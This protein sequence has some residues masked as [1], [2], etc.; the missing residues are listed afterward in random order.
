MNGYA[1]LVLEDGTIIHG[2][3]IG[4]DGDRVGEVIF[5]TAMCGYQEIITDP[6]YCRQIITFSY[7]HIGNTGV[8]KEDEESN[9]I[10]ASGIVIGNR[11][12]HHPHHRSHESLIAYLHRHQTVA[13]AGVD[14]RRLIHLLRKKG[15]QRACITAAPTPIDVTSALEKARAF[16]GLGGMDLAQEVGHQYDWP[17]ND[18]ARYSVVA[19][20]FGIKR[21]ILRLMAQ[22]DCSI[23]VVPATTPAE[24]V[25]AMQPDGIFLSN[26][27]GDPLPCD[28]AIAA[29]HTFLQHKIP[30]FGI[31]LGHQLLAVAVGAQVEKMKLGHHGANHPVR[32]LKDNVV[33]ISSQ[34]HGFVVSDEHLP[35]RIEVT[36]RSL[37]DDTIQ[38]IRVRDCPAFGFQGHPEA[39]PGPHDMHGLFADFLSLMKHSA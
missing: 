39:S 30:L 27:P 25:L 12:Q 38:G 28:Y 1:A 31:C 2:D 32:R 11:I 20:N 23:A 21:N 13:V 37:F 14:T 19:Y 18:R 8:N 10:W 7:P 9:Q 6:S 36:H 4:C 3:S 33:A 15:A 5:N 34:N 26:G 17:T 35:A 16:P 22:H 24:E 29:I